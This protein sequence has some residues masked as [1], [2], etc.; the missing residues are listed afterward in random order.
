MAFAHTFS[1]VARC[2][3]SGQLGVAVQSHWFAVGT[4]VPWA[5]AG[6][7]VV[8]TQSLVEPSYGP[9][10]LTAMRD[11]A[12]AAEA[13][14]QLLAVDAGKDVRQIGMV[15]QHGRAAAWTGPRCVA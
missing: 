9:Q 10:G 3:S 1:I 13:L 11:G 8:A 2:P 5:E 6:V 12:S 4:V 15:D 14:A 7:G